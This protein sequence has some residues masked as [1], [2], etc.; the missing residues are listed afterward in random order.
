MIIGY[1]VTVL[2]GKRI[3]NDMK[4]IDK[5]E[6]SGSGD[7]GVAVCMYHFSP[8]QPIFPVAYV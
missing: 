8:P 5:Y 4:K 3:S 6:D 7:Y 1:F 2:T